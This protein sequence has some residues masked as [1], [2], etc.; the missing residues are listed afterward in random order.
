[1]EKEYNDL[2]DTLT[3]DEYNSARDSVLN[4]HYTSPEI[5]QAIFA[6]VKQ[7]GFNGGNILEPAVGSGRF[8][9]LCLK[10]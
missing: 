6:A 8:L 9:N 10:I 3:H 1:M 2:R 5:I 4:A 7:M